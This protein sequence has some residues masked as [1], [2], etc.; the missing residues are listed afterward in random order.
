MRMYNK[1]FFKSQCASVCFSFGIVLDFFG[2]K[3]LYHGKNWHVKLVS[4]W[5]R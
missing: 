4:F 5:A 2:E 3:A 1:F